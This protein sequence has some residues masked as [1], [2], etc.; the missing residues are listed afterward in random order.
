LFHLVRLVVERLERSAMTASVLARPGPPGETHFDSLEVDQGV[1]SD[2]R[3]LV[4]RCIRLF[5]ELGP[6]IVSA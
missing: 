4:V 1:H 6:G 3:T 5:A 2:C